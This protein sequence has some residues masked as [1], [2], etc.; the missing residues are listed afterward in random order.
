MD[1]NQILQPGLSREETF[2]VEEQHSAIH[3]GSG[4]LRVLATP[5]LITFMER[6]ARLLLSERLPPGYS[7]VGVHVDVYHLA[8]SPVGAVVRARAEVQ[9]IEGMRVNFIVQAWDNQEKIGEGSHQRVVIDEG[10]FLRRVAAKVGP[11]AGQ[12]I[13]PA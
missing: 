10:R 1:L 7:S 8:P 6:T 4:S 5:W 11:Q 3:V 9:S 12:G 2:V 13:T